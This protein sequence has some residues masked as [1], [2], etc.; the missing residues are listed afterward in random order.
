ML[1]PFRVF[2]SGSSIVL[3]SLRHRDA[4]EHFGEAPAGAERRVLGQRARREEAVLDDLAAGLRQRL[5][6]EAA[7]HEDGDMV[8]ARAR[9][10]VK[11]PM[12]HRRVDEPYIALLDELALE[13]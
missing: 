2:P 3:P 9:R 4:V 7:D 11:D 12:K 8:A 5:L 10:I 6:A 13:R 1:S